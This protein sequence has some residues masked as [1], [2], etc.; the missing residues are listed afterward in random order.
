MTMRI[1]EK[2]AMNTVDAI[3]TKPFKVKEIDKTIQ[4]LL[5]GAA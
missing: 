4:N 2:M 1:G 5:S 3:V